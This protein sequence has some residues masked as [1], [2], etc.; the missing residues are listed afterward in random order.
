MAEFRVPLEFCTHG[1]L[2]SLP[3]QV[4]ALLSVT[5]EGANTGV[6]EGENSMILSGGG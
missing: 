2:L 4:L 3:A 5:L 1:E 6:M